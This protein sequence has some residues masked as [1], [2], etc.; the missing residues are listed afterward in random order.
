MKRTHPK[1]NPG[2]FRN[3]T[4]TVMVIDDRR[5]REAHF[6]PAVQLLKKIETLGL[7]IDAFHSHDQKKFDSWFNLTFR[8]EQL[9]IEQRREEWFQLAQTHNWILAESEM[10]GVSLGE[11]WRRI[12]EEIMNY[13]TAGENGRAVI[14]QKRRERESFIEAEIARQEREDLN[15]FRAESEKFDE[16]YDEDDDDE[17]P[18][19][20]RSPSEAE[21][22]DFAELKGLSETDF[23]EIFASSRTA[24]EFLL[25]SLQLCVLCSGLGVFL[26]IWQDACPRKTKLSFERF[27]ENETGESFRNVLEWI[28]DEAK[29]TAEDA[30]GSDRFSKS[31][32]DSESESEFDFDSDFDDEDSQR[33]FFAGISSGSQKRSL[34]EDKLGVLKGLYRKLVR[35]L[36]PDGQNSSPLDLPATWTQKTWERLQSAYKSQNLDELRRIHSLTLLQT[37]DLNALTM[38]EISEG[39][40]ELESELENLENQARE[41]KRLPAWNFSNKRSTT[42]IEKKI[43]Q[44]FQRDLNEI[45]MKISILLFQHKKWEQMASQKA[46]RSERRARRPKAGSSGPKNSR[47]RSG[48]RDADSFF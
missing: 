37:R 30:A 26:K 39:I 19:P 46:Q 29:S 48:E 28:V 2:I 9:K 15:R 27:F 16:W 14:D 12:Q 7:R 31:G 18:S 47:R 8:Q 4:R 22:A 5:L 24:H 3:Q 21:K 23:D 38:D 20:I 43:R 40:N 35:L 44:D 33:E 45:D 10:N 17:L 13:G 32:A 41:M 11:A 34:S 36:H 1:V 6:A 25:R 42:T